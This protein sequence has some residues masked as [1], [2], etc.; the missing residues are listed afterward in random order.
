GTLMAGIRCGHGK[1]P[2]EGRLISSRLS[3]SRLC[4]RTV[5]AAATL[6]QVLSCPILGKREGEADAVSLA[7]GS[8]P[9]IH[10]SIDATVRRQSR[11]GRS[12]ARTLRAS[13]R[14]KLSASDLKSH[15]WVSEL[16]HVRT[17][18]IGLSKR[19]N[20]QRERNDEYDRHL[21]EILQKSWWLLFTGNDIVFTP[22]IAAILS[23][24]LR[25]RSEPSLCILPC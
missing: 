4:N 20:L 13:C 25:R 6:L 17:L 19:S 10:H 7:V 9:A 5:Q 1:A 16:R 18:R 11:S 14:H 12:A 23:E 15:A 3:S 8:C 2:S 24:L 21:H 22:I